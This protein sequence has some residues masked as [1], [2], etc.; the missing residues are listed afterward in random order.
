VP[1]SPYWIR[2]KNPANKKE[3]EKKT[4]EQKI[5]KRLQHSCEDVIHL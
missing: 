1:R 4:E 3:N 2:E 5:K